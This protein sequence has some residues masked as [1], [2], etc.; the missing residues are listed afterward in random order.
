[1]Y[2]CCSRGRRSNCCCNCQFLLSDGIQVGSSNIE[3][4]NQQEKCTSS[5]ND[6]WWHFWAKR[7]LVSFFSLPTDDQNSEPLSQLNFQI[8]WSHVGTAGFAKS[9]Y[10]LASWELGD[11]CKFH[12][13]SAGVCQTSAGQ[14]EFG[15]S[16]VRRLSLRIRI[17]WKIRLNR[18]KAATS[19]IASHAS[20]PASCA[21][22][23]WQSCCRQP[24]QWQWYIPSSLNTVYEKALFAAVPTAPLPW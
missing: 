2:C 12:Y 13:E 17:D 8:F 11:S 18:L 19:K 22:V 10:L 20:S 23:P 6:F 1:M 7:F 9:S 14:L 5:A 3:E 4:S 21:F 16:I 15:I 24:T